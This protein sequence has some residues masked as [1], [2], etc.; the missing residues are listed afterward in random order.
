M[1]TIK[2]ITPMFLCCVRI[3]VALIIIL[4]LQLASPVY[5]DPQK[6]SRLYEDAL[7]R[8]DKGDLQGTV[9]QLKNAIQQDD[10]M[11][12]AHLLLGK[13]LFKQG[14]LKGAEAAFE[15]ALKLGVDR[16]E[17]VV[18]LEQNRGHPRFHDNYDACN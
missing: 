4:G 14:Q 16:G 12:P 3:Y 17:V 5:A 15:E 11:L 7:R 9:I 18:Q 8:F 2:S 10:K 1:K 13:T 6:A